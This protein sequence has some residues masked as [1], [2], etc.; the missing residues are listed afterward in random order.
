[1]EKNLSPSFATQEFAFFEQKCS[2]GRG[3]IVLLLFQ[4]FFPRRMFTWFRPFS[5][6]FIRYLQVIRDRKSVV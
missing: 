4:V 3:K 5:A 6:F 2:F 1:M